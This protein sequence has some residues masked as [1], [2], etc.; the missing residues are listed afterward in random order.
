MPKLWKHIPFIKFSM[1]NTYYI[2]TVYHSLPRGPRF[3]IEK[4]IILDLFVNIDQQQ[5]RTF[6]AY[7]EINDCLNTGNV[8]I[9]LS[10]KFGH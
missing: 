6:V 3:Q 7:S 5:E 9:W 8:R 1:Q 10:G 4:A 2:S